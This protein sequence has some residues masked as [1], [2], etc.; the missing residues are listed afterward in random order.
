MHHLR[1]PGSAL[2]A[3]GTCARWRFWPLA[4]AAL[5]AGFGLR[6]QALAATPTRLY[7]HGDPLPEEQYMLEL[8]NR[9]RANPVAEAAMDGIDLNEGL[10]PGTIPTNAVQPL[11][12]NP[13]LITSARGHS[14]WMLTNGFF[15]HYETNSLGTVLDPGDRMTNA[16]Y[17][18]SGSWAWGENIS[19]E[20]TTGPPPPVAPTVEDE[21]NNLFIDTS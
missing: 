12:F 21:E 9:A 2:A 11:A 20:G 16:G 6:T 7:S 3:R 15:S 13:D 8:V 1:N 5:L 14:Q 4:V 19:W 10:S 18:F 17:V